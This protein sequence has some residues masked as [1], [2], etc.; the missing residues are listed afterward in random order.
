MQS[1][2]LRVVVAQEGIDIFLRDKHLEHLDARSGENEVDARAL[3][4]RLLTEVVPS[5]VNTFHRVGHAARVVE[6]KFVA[7]D[8]GVGVAGV[9]NIEV[10]GEECRR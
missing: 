4:G 8:G 1:S 9:V 6:H 5:V 10:A 3:V 7:G 2:Y